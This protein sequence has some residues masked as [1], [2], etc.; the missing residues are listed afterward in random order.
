[1]LNN[2]EYINQ[3]TTIN[4][5]YIRSLKIY[6][7]IINLSIIN[8][9]YKKITEE[10]NQKCDNLLNEIININN[11]SIQKE[12]YN[13]EILTTKYTIKSEEITN[14]LFNTKINTEL[15]KKENNIKIETNIYPNIKEIESLNQKSKN[16]A[17]NFQELTSE[18]KK[19]LNNQQSF[20][21]L[22]PSFFTLMYDETN[23]FIK[24]IERL[25]NKEKISPLY[26]MGYDYYFNDNLIKLTKYLQNFI[27]P[28]NID[29]IDNISF[30]QNNL[31]NLTNDYLLKNNN[32][33]SQQNLRNKSLDI[34][35]KLKNLIETTMQKII[36]GTVNVI[37]PIIT[38]DNILRTINFYKYVLNIN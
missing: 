26:V 18:I 30:Y 35:E 38:I 15:T 16:L 13:E 4:L 31:K 24:D 8:E 11:I 23:M 12:I 17:K 34:I 14:K 22:Y 9:N 19:E 21:Y 28:I 27:D 33:E 3:S 36:N 1:M 32:P 29:I 20:S 6:S 25:E 10:F 7:I 5:Y 37:T 2:Q